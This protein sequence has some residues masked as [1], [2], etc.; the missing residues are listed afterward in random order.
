MP[1]PMRAATVVPYAS[2]RQ[3]NPVMLDA[4]ERSGIVALQPIS[5]KLGRG[6]YM[7]RA[8]LAPFEL[9]LAEPE[10]QHACVE[11]LVQHGCKFIRR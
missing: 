6:P 11:D 7:H 1:T 8:V 9:A 2:T 10:H 4:A 3:V 5:D